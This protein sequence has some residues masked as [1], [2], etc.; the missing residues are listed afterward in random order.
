MDLRF[1]CIHP[2]SFNCNRLFFWQAR[3]FNVSYLKWAQ[4][5]YILPKHSTCKCVIMPLALTLCITVVFDLI[6]SWS[7]T[8]DNF[9]LSTRF[10]DQNRNIVCAANLSIYVPKNTYSDA[11]EWYMWFYDSVHCKMSY[12][13][14]TMNLTEI[15]FFCCPTDCGR[16]TGIHMSIGTL[17]P[18]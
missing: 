7:S 10:R 11:I 15:M 4:E 2:S 6:A 18:L 13:D 9:S 1:H 14:F 16:R 12:C 5:L 17:W 8:C 3:S